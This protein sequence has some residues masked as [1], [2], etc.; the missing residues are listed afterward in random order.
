MSKYVNHMLTENGVVII[1]DDDMVAVPDENPLFNKLKGLLDDHEFDA[2]P[3]VVDRANYLKMYTGGAFSV[4]AD[5]HILIGEEILPLSMSKRL[6]GLIDSDSP[7]DPVLKFWD[8]LGDAPG[9]LFDFLDKIG[10]PLLADGRF[11]CYKRV[12]K[13]DDSEVGRK[14]WAHD[15]NGK[16]VQFDAVLGDLVDAH[17]KTIRNNVGDKPLM[18]R[19]EVDDDRDQTCSHGLHVAAWTYAKNWYTNGVLIEVAVF[20]QDVVAIPTDY[21]QEKM[22]TCQYEVIRIAGEPRLEPLAYSVGDAVRYDDPIQG[23]VVD[24]VITEAK[25]GHPNKYDIILPGEDDNPVLD[26]EKGSLSW[27]Q[28]IYDDDDYGDYGYGAVYR[29]ATPVEDDD[30]EE[31]CEVIEEHCQGCGELAMNCQCD[32][33]DQLAAIDTDAD[34]Q[35]DK[36]EP[37]MEDLRNSLEGVDDLLEEDEDE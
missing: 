16:F 9:D 12:H 8:N 33:D 34:V 31:E 18:N 22:R 10:I 23:K 6:F 14:I 19:A 26:V 27:P 15:E 32:T 29:S 4:N 25:P 5:G 37:G 11:L 36:E 2:I 20:A 24:A 17:S 1:L 7:F 21:E 3:G 13:I 30:N 28:V 35:G